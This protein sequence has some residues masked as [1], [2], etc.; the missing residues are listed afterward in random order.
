MHLYS[1]PWA[2][3]VFEQ[4]RNS[5]PRATDFFLD[6]H[7][8]TREPIIQRLRRN[9]PT[10]QKIKRGVKRLERWLNMHTFDDYGHCPTQVL[11]SLWDILNEILDYDSNTFPR[12]LTNLAGS[13]FL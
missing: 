12:P 5:C 6:F 2:S 9:S 1:Y 13:L 3:E 8:I 10:W 7:H 4:F 11:S